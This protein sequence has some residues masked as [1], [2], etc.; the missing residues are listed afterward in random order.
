M[1]K[2]GKKKKASAKRALKARRKDVKRALYKSYSE[3]GQAKK[4]SEHKTQAS[5]KKHQHIVADCGNTGCVHCYPHL[6]KRILG[7]GKLKS[8][9]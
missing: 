3:L 2:S 7:N 8:A 5:G 9:S 4:D 1:S 6:N